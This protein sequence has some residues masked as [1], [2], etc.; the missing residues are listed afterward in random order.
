[1]SESQIEEIQNRL[2]NYLFID[3]FERDYRTTEE[4]ATE[5]FQDL[6]VEVLNYEETP[7]PL[8]DANWQNLP[9]HDWPS[10][11]R[12]NAARLFAESGNF[13]V[14][15]V[16]LEKL[17]KTAERKVV[18]SL[19][20]SERT[21]GWAL[22]GSF[23]AVFHAPEGDVW[24]LVTPYEE[25]SDDITEGRSVIRRYII[26]EGE[27]HHTVSGALSQM[28]ADKTGRLADRINE[29][30][31][32]QP[33]TQ[34][35]YQDYKSVFE[36]LTS[37]LRMKGLGIED[38]D[39]YAHII[40]NRLMFFYYLQKKGWI[41]GRKD[42]IDWFHKQYQESTDQDCFHEKWLSTLFFEGMNQPAGSQVTVDLPIEV[43]DTISNIPEMNGGLFKKYGVDN[44][45]VYLSDDAL[46]GVIQGFLEQYN[47]TI[48]EESPYD[49]DV[50][51]DP[52]MLGKIYESLIAE[53]ERGEAG[54]FYTP[55]EEVDFMCRMA[56]YEQFCERAGTLD[57][58]AK[59]QIVEFL[60]REVQDWDSSDVGDTDELEDIL[61]NLRIVDPACG[62]GAFLV[63]MKQVLTELYRKL[64][65]SPDYQLKEQII[66]ENLHGVDIKDW[67]VRV[68]E[69]RLWL[70][71]IQGEDEIPEQRPI[72]PNFSFK[73]RRGDSL[74]Q[75][76]GTGELLSFEEIRRGATDEVFQALQG[77][78]EVK[79]Q[80]FAGGIND[81]DQIQQQQIKLLTKYID[82]R[83]ESLEDEATTQ[84]TLGGDATEQSKKTAASIKQKI[85][86][87]QDIKEQ[88]ETGDL[89]DFIWELDYPEVMIDGGFDI[90]IGNPPYVRQEDIIDQGINP[91][92]IQDMDNSEV[93]SL[94]SEYKEGLRNFVEHQ[95]DVKPYK[96]SDLYLYFF[97]RSIDI[98]RDNGTLSFVTSNSWL[99]VDYGVRLQEFLLT[100]GEI[101]YIFESR[102]Q[103][104]FEEADVNTIISII[105]KRD[106]DSLS[107]PTEFVS[108]YTGYDQFLSMNKLHS[109]L[110]VGGGSGN[111]LQFQNEEIQI[112]NND[113]WR[114]VSIPAESL[115]R[116]GGGKT[117]DPNED[118]SVTPQGKYKTG[119]W[120]KYTRAPTVFFEITSGTSQSLSNLGNE[121]ELQRGTRTGA[122]QFFYLPSKYYDVT[123]DGHTL[124]LQSTGNWP[125]DDY[126][127]QL[128]I[129]KEYWMHETEEGWEPNLI[130]KTSKSF[131][132][133]IFDLDSLKIGE[134]LR[135][136]LVIDKPE[137]D[138]KGGIRE[139]IKWGE[140]YDPSQ[141][142]L[143][144]KTTGFPSSVSGRGVDWYDLT[145][146]LTRGD[147]L[148][149]KN[150][151]TR[152]V[153]WFPNQ[154]TWIDDRLH[155]IEVPGDE[156]NRRFLAGVLNSTY[157]T[158]SCEVN[159]RV[160]LG[161]GALDIATDDH[162]L[163]II[164]KLDEVD[165]DL[166]KKIASQFEKLGSRSVTSLF[167][168][169]GATEPDQ[170][171]FDSVRDDRLEL[172]QLVIQELLGFDQNTHLNVYRGTLNLVK[173]R[174]EKAESV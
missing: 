84:H 171:S 25:E 43:D 101:D 70:S 98:L 132:T 115:W 35:F 31:R 166:K 59:G 9:V 146:D 7:S 65:L 78:E 105:N 108:T 81:P 127:T 92:R 130:L 18:Q 12:A 14:I 174:I 135:Y 170:V 22:S 103:R 32:V 33:V 20:R 160:N 13:R 114:S 123:V 152:H 157:G 15:Y 71:L 109:L 46:H 82:Q 53:Q 45:N 163:A 39:R 51:V 67:A 118:G 140:T 158:L 30:F 68:A 8:G 89:D 122:N 54:I 99:D 80:F 19:T 141:D 149:M 79:E 4:A 47:F 102:T 113:T 134:S 3:L 164:P 88:V 151:N 90:A 24:H 36:N 60:F 73:L 125:D 95:F 50:A 77:L 137:S 126:E 131:D 52:A 168:E 172:D 112:S 76:V 83:V 44:S 138:L 10:S 75:T 58:K 155:G 16:E 119:K 133:T 55:R 136:V 120:G 49:I 23:L 100:N 62:S 21:S 26:G 38:A 69:F 104:T 139:Y 94:K 165:E 74:I 86:D 11:T 117:S 143:G 121:C 96:T 63:G 56:L 148:P 2:D 107:A 6:F 85:A 28:D 106:Q 128:E 93:S 97:F 87:L 142:D 37:E 91:E 29:A 169:L 159:G 162:K 147:I 173:Q 64:G 41:G 129:P 1:M 153:Y 17:T 40:L 72:L 5:F 66:N 144:R 116:L 111:R 34:D 145:E 57:R 48:T 156:M 161:Q 42:F 154:R 167:D 150:I 110:A 124:I 61:H 27:T